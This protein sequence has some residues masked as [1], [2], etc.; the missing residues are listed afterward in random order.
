MNVEQLR[1]HVDLQDGRGGIKKFFCKAEGYCI[2]LSER[3]FSISRADKL[4]LCTP[5]ENCISFVP[6]LT[7]GSE[8]ISTKKARASTKAS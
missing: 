8:E 2:T 7:N 3:V 1:T 5:M 6:E 4:I